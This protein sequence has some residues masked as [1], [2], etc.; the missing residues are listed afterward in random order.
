MEAAGGA[1]EASL[2]PRLSRRGPEA[3]AAEVEA[4]EGNGGGTAGRSLEGRAEAEKAGTRGEEDRPSGSLLG[5]VTSEGT[6][7]APASAPAM[8]DSAR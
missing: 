4:G 1:A 8:P 5:T 6:P 3:A 7:S 2:R